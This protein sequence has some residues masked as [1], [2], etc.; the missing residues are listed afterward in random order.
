MKTVY[1]W[2]VGGT[3]RR[4]PYFVC[5]LALLFVGAIAAQVGKEMGPGVFVTTWCVV[6]LLT[7]VLDAT[8]LRDIGV[9]GKIALVVAVTYIFAWAPYTY[10]VLTGT[11]L[12]YPF[13]AYLLPA[14]LVYTL[15]H[16]Y[17]LF[18]KPKTERRATD[19]V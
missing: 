9:P 16:L 8:R 12:P 13:P 14:Q 1:E 10:D 18:A 5:L 2:I 6:Y 3:L 19:L 7:S 4:L 17:L 11:R 15:G